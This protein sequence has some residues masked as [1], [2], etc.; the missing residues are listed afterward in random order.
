MQ[1][2]LDWARQHVGWT[3]NDWTTVLFTDESKFC[4]DFTDRRARVWRAR[5]ER[6]APV[7]VAELDRYGKGSVMVLAGISM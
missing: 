5:Y 2:L 1:E 4:S 6:F 7:C 3:F